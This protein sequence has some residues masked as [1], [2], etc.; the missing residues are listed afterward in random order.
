MR[1]QKN[2]LKKKIFK[3]FFYLVS[4][5]KAKQTTETIKKENKKVNKY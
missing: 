1:K 4:F 2:S 5:K 3:E